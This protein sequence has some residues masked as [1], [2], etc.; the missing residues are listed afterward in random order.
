MRYVLPFRHLTGLLIAAMT[1]VAGPPV[2]GQQEQAPVGKQTSSLPAAIAPFFQP[3]ADLAQ[4]YGSYESPLKFS[5]GRRVESRAQWPA[6]RAEILKTWHD[7]MGPWPPLL[8]NPKLERLE[9]TRR[10]NFTQHRVQLE[11][12]P[13]W[14]SNG[15]LLVPDGDGPFPA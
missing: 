6:R 14:T 3:P 13:G 12:A 5:D 2:A 7:L 1:T 15:Y 10:E 4:D 11:T 8:E 9:Q